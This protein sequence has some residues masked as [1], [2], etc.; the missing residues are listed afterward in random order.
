MVNKPLVRTYSHNK[1]GYV[2][3]PEGTPWA[4]NPELG[5]ADSTSTWKVLHTKF[6][7][8]HSSNNFHPFLQAAI[9]EKLGKQKN[10]NLEKLTWLAGK[11][12]HFQLEILC[13]SSIMVDFPAI[14]MLVNSGGYTGY[15]HEFWQ[16]LFFCISPTYEFWQQ[17]NAPQKTHI[18][19]PRAFE[20]G[21]MNEMNSLPPVTFSKYSARDL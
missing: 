15:I 8:V 18:H 5:K 3:S 14:V 1:R 6:L 7:K 16:N 20:K 11:I 9:G 4:W 2:R 19:Y 21:E 17:K 13:I 12:N 10:S